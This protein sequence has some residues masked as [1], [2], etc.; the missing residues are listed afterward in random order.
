MLERPQV[1]LVWNTHVNESP[2]TFVMAKKLEKE[3]EKRGITVRIQK[4][5]FEKSHSF[6]LSRAKTIQEYYQS[7][8]E[9]YAQELIE[10]N[11]QA[12]VIKLHNSPTGV[13]SFGKKPARVKFWRARKTG[14]YSM[15][16]RDHLALIPDTTFGRGY[17]LEFP[18]IARPATARLL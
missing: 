6:G 7:Y 15:T 3:L 13:Y 9:S 14:R 2:A 8:D 18:V 10:Q 17:V 1:I 12:L 11:P 4:I 5:P 16:K